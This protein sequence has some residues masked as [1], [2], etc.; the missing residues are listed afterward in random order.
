LLIILS[1]GIVVAILAPFLVGSLR[2]SKNEIINFRLNPGIVLSLIPVG[3]FI[4]F[5]SQIPL[6]SSGTIP[7]ESY[8]WIESLS[9]NL[10]FRL[11][12]IGLLFSLM[13]TGIG[14][15]IVLYAGNYLNKHEDLGKFYSYLFLFMTA[16]IGVSVSDN[17]F[18]FFLFWELTSI[19]SYLLI[20][21]NH[22]EDKSRYS[23]LQALLVTGG[24]GLALFAGFLL[25]YTTTG[26]SS[27]SELFIY[28]GTLSNAVELSAMI[29]FIIGI[30]T[31]SAQMP[32]HF[33]LPAAM[34]APT[35]VS[36]YLHSATMVKAGVFL[37]A[38]LNPYFASVEYWSETLMIIG[39][40]TMLIAA[41]MGVTQTDLKRL[42]AYSTLS[43]LGMLI[44]LIGMNSYESLTAFGVVVAAHTLYKAT[45]FLVAGSVDHSV[46]T[47]D[48]TQLGALSRIMPFTTTAGA[49]AAL[50]M[51]GV[52]PFA[53][54]L[55]KEFVYE[56]ATQFGYNTVLLVFLFFVTNSLLGVIALR[57]GVGVFWGNKNNIST[58][59]AHESHW[60]IVVPPLVFG[61]LGIVL[62]IFT[63][64]TTAFFNSVSNSLARDILLRELH[65]WHGFTLILLLSIITIVVSTIVFIV[66]AKKGATPFEP[67]F[68]FF[69]TTLFGSFIE[70]LFKVAGAVTK[71]FQNGKLRWY[72]SI[73]FLFAVVLIGSSL[74]F[75]TNALTFAF[76]VHVTIYEWM[77]T[78][79]IFVALVIVIQS[80][81]RLTA[82]AAMGIV[83]YAIALFFVL[84]SAP[85][86]ALTQFT[87]ETLTVV[88]F[89]FAIYKLPKNVTVPDRNTK[90]R[91]AS[92]A[93][94]IGSI[95]TLSILFA[96][97]SPSVSEL[98]VFY[99][100]RSL[101]EAYGRN[102]VNVIIVDFRA[103]DTLGEIIVLAVA[104]LGI[105][106][107]LQF[108]KGEQK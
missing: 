52:I 37:A 108:S 26:I 102:V 18:A 74:P 33:W 66:I 14:A 8:P 5:L 22:K 72:I 93:L 95:V 57:T 2:Y 88:L 107:L 92:I 21:F 6:I 100:T 103:L 27:F 105:V 67:K 40:T 1:I 16:M 85:D 80:N 68:S 96:A 90:L 29:L 83:G 79:A 62:G 58:E 20:G 42:L 43:V 9:I 101:V 15:G 47:R 34:A 25:L 54:F 76:P 89:M 38:R 51:L 41:L 55:A 4:F 24:G 73:T 35:P 60:Q 39:G 77:L 71:F 10:S 65:L 45:L 97:G 106:A 7:F 82:I 59:H 70:I 17:F 48:V 87:I 32:F 81:S 91:D 61:F 36:A 13:I 44:T 99:N 30:S 75:S 86:L 46:H 28:N 50:S 63:S 53:G 31:K 49:L 104:A 23:A 12:G 64:G 11:D 69:P 98:E 94:S 56:S 19:S 84:Y 78:A 3:M